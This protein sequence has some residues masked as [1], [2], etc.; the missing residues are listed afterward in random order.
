MNISTEEQ[1]K[2]RALA[3]MAAR[4]DADRLDIQELMEQAWSAGAAYCHRCPEVEVQEVQQRDNLAEIERETILRVYVECGENFKE[5][6]ARLGIGKTKLFRKLKDYGH[7]RKRI[8]NLAPPHVCPRCG[9]EYDDHV[10]PESPKAME[11][12]CQ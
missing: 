1:G 2:I 3:I 4:P 11:T 8:R 9:F 7:Q 12:G 6:T 10:V 5:S